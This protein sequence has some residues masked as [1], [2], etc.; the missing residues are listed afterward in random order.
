MRTVVV[1]G[2]LDFFQ[3]AF[4]AGFDFVNAVDFEHLEFDVFGQDR[5]HVG[6]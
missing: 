1:D 3:I 6:V 2:D 4:Q 5:Q